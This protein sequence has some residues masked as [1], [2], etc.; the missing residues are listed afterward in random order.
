MKTAFIA[1]V[2]SLFL[3]GCASSVMLPDVSARKKP[4]LASAKVN[5]THYHPVITGYVHRKP[6][7]PEPWLTGDEPPPTTE[8]DK[9]Q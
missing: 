9:K 2:T 3:T 6:T 1:V 7:S 5:P 8:G 4:A